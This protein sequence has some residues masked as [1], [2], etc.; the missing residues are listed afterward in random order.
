MWKREEE[1]KASLLSIGRGR[2]CEWR[3]ERKREKEEQTP[4]KI[5]EE[6]RNKWV[7]NKESKG[8]DVGK[9]GVRWGE[10]LSKGQGEGEGERVRG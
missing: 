6:K 9:D 3:R 2:K 5:K 10:R 1:R 8:T 7:L 4:R